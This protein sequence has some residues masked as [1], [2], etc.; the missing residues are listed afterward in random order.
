MSD[1]LLG[2]INAIEDIRGCTFTLYLLADCWNKSV[3]E[4]IIQMREYIGTEFQRTHRQNRHLVPASQEKQR[5][6]YLKSFH[7]S[8][9]NYSCY[10]ISVLPAV[11]LRGLWTT[12]GGDLDKK[13]TWQNWPQHFLLLISSE[14][15]VE[16]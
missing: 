9:L 16:E 1:Y 15:G 3:G 5:S 13:E 14:L 2:Q 11:V 10:S 12:K 8:S 7:H 4:Q 6:Y